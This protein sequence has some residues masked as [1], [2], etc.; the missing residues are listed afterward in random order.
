MG[1][2][3]HW[4]IPFILLSQSQPL[5]FSKV[6]NYITKEP[7]SLPPDAFPGLWIT[8]GELRARPQTH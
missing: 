2:P 3:Q 1:Q 5:Y 4:R 7:K 8:L 6:R